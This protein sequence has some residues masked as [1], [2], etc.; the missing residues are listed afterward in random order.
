MTKIFLFAAVIFFQFISF[1]GPEQVTCFKDLL[2]ALKS[3]KIV[4]VITDY[5]KCK[6]VIDGKE[7]KAPE[8]IGGMNINAFEYFDRGSVRNE[9]AFISASETPLILHPR[10][11]HVL[12]Y[13]KIRIFEDDEVEI[14]ARYLDPKTFEVKFD[15]IYLSSI[16]NNENNAGVTIFLN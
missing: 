15:A 3:G 10:Y 1:G 2:D 12:N 4:R 14:T 5:A 16:N 6:L 9:R 8:A 7:E 13:V 11:G